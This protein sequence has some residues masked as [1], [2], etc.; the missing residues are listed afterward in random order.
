LLFTVGSSTDQ[1]AALGAGKL[2]ADLPELKPLAKYSDQRL[3]DISYVSKA[4]L[5]AISN[6]NR[7]LD[8]LVNVVRKVLPEAGLPE[9]LKQRITKDAE[10]L[11]GDVKATVPTLGA[12]TT[13][14]FL[15]P[16]GNESY[17]YDWSQDL[18]SDFSKPLDLL[19]HMGGD[20]IL[21]V[22]GRTKYSPQE[23]QTLRKWL[24]KG[25][26]YFEDF[27]VPNFSIEERAQYA[28][29][30]EIALPLIDQLDKATGQMLLP[31]LANGQTG[32]ALDAKSTSKRWFEGMPE[33]EQPLPMIEAV[34]LAIDPGSNRS[35]S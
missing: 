18:V 6:T 17:A 8:E 31:A 24:I 22:A 12:H 5:Q 16:R 25:F 1:L 21:A 7:D 32:F 2:L 30:K 10:E 27:G 3:V 15:T 28:K 20:P 19:D 34:R 35:R 23:Y 4:M 33:A 26:S 14:S 9:E 13:F 29:I 11:A